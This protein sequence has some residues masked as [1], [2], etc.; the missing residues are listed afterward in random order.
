MFCQTDLQGLEV[1]QW[2]FSKKGNYAIKT[3]TMEYRVFLYFIQD[4]EF[5]PKKLCYL[6]TFFFNIKLVAFD[7]GSCTA[8]EV[9][10]PGHCNSQPV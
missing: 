7:E 1:A 2:D 4:Q 6:Q 10:P 9:F 5:I 3:F 8:L